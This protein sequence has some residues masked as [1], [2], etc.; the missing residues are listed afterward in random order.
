MAF[1]PYEAYTQQSVMTMTPGEMLNKLY[2][3]T[4]KQLRYAEVYLE[5]KDYGKVNGALQKAQRILNYLRNTLDFQYEVSKGLD[6]LYEY[7]IQ[8]I[9]KANIHKDAAPLAEII[10][11]LSE[12]QQTFIQADKLARKQ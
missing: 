12:L 11:M 4:V 2:D 9:V 6:A 1:N 3:E 5:K 7:F 8:Q 10:P